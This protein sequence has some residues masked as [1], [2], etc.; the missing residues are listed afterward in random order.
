MVVYGLCFTGPDVFSRMLSLHHR[1]KDRT[2][3]FSAPPNQ[4]CAPWERLDAR[5]VLA[6]ARDGDLGVRAN[7]LEWLRP[8]LNT[9]TFTVEAPSFLVLLCTFH[10]FE[11]IETLMSI[12]HS[13]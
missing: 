8:L 1:V 12:T 2:N 3:P 6:A 5:T 10:S 4:L 9:F 7:N 13:L 11:A